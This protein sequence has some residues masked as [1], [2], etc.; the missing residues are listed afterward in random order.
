[1]TSLQENASTSAT[2]VVALKIT[3]PFS[4]S[5]SSI[6][7]IHGHQLKQYPRDIKNNSEI[8]WKRFTI[9]NFY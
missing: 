3:S 8:F 9:K 2:E 5:V 4:E 1:M 6:Y 7:I